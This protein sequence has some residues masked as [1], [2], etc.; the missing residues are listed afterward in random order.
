MNIKQLHVLQWSPSQQAFHE[1]TI[2]TML[3]E[4][5]KAMAGKIK[6]P[7]YDWFPVAIAEQPSEWQEWLKRNDRSYRILAECGRFKERLAYIGFQ[8]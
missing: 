3:A 2:E 6:N 5:K 4:N 7:N 1:D 8:Y